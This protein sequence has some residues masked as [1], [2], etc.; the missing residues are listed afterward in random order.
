MDT[1]RLF[2][3]KSMR[4]EFRKKFKYDNESIK[5]W[6]YQQWLIKKLYLIRKSKWWYNF[7]KKR[8]LMQNRQNNVLLSNVE[9]HTSLS[10]CNQ[11]FKSTH[12]Q[13]KLSKKVLEQYSKVRKILR[14][15]QTVFISFCYSH[16]IVRNRQKL[17]SILRTSK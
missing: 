10:R 5:L 16:F 17:Q 14:K 8:K 12:Y 4:V 2:E 9:K 3:S 11:Q 1:P 6:W 15:S 13:P 7:F